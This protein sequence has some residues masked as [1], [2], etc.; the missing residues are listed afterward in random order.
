MSRLSEEQIEVHL[1]KL[2]QWEQQD[3]T[4]KKVFTFPGFLKAVA[5]VNTA[6]EI[7]E[8]NDHHPDLLIQYDK[9]TVTLTT[10]DEQGITGKD[11]LVA[12]ELDQS[13]E[14]ST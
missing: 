4:I 5:F 3:N 9:V 2:K 12:E 1:G 11:L 7:A 13:V 10:H 14:K 8:R 6:A